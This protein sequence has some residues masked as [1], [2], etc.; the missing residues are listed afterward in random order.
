MNLFIILIKDTY[1]YISQRVKYM[2]L[3]WSSLYLRHTYIQSIF[4]SMDSVIGRYCYIGYNTSITRTT[5]WNYSSI[6]NNV[7]IGMGEHELDGVSTNSL[8]Y[9]NQY[10]KLTSS[11]CVIWNDVWIGVDSIIRRGVTVGNG[12]VIGANSFVNQD[13]PPYA[14][15]AWSPAKLIRYRFSEEKIKTIESSLWWNHD[16]HQA[17]D[18][19][20]KITKESHA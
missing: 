7:S 6:A 8:F 18:I 11:P 16:P 10:E 13:V 5:I 2:Y 9:D 14:I 1:V 3:R 20:S 15:V 19:F 4:V 17:K 12:A